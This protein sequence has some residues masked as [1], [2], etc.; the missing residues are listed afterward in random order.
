MEWK[1]FI[2]D[3]CINFWTSLKIGA[4]TYLIVWWI[5]LA[6]RM[7]FYLQKM[8]F[9]YSQWKWFFR[10]NF[11]FKKKTFFVILYS[12]LFSLHNCVAMCDWKQRKYFTHSQEVGI[13]V[14]CKFDFCNINLI[15][16][17]FVN[18]FLNF[19]FKIMPSTILAKKMFSNLIFLKQFYFKTTRSR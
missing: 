16:D 1:T 9:I 14:I 17:L 8:S 10:K 5:Y 13:T 18:V 4:I 7:Q 12:T 11:R 3:D 19:I 15:D 6:T 2:I